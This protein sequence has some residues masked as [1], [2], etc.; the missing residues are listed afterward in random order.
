MASQRAKKDYIFKSTGSLDFMCFILQGRL[1]LV[2][3]EFLENVQQKVNGE[4][5]SLK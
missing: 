2:L 5:E 3:T 1:L 4:C